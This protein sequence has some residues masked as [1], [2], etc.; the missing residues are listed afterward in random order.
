M[1][2]CVLS[3]WS[4]SLR[5]RS[6]FTLRSLT[7]CSFT[8]WFMNCLARPVNFLSSP[9]QGYSRFKVGFEGQWISNSIERGQFDGCSF[10][11]LRLCNST[12][13]DEFIVRSA[14]SICE[15]SRNSPWLSQNKNWIMRAVLE[16]WNSSKRIDFKKFWLLRQLQKVSASLG[17]INNIDST[18]LLLT[19]DD[20]QLMNV[21]DFETQLR[22][23]QL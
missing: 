18:Y 17:L 5:T 3:F 21:G 16:T 13:R 2:G 15:I 11:E 9:R 22:N 14:I 19:L 8:S 23:H 10:F 1:K 6:S 7:T 12:V 20:V 4:R